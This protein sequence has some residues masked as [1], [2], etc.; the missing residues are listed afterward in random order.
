MDPMIIGQIVEK[1]PSTVTRYEGPWTARRGDRASYAIELIEQSN[2]GDFRFKV[3][4][5]NSEDADSAA[6][7]LTSDITVGT[8][9]GLVETS[10]TGAKEWV[11]YVIFTV[12]DG[13][14]GFIAFRTLDPQW[15]EN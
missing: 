6:T 5:K 15:A 13:D 12:N 14:A 10:A 8:T 11:R 4:T 3:E 1:K 2:G 9:A 7:N